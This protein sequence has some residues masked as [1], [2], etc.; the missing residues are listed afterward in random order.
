[1]IDEKKRAF[2]TAGLEFEEQAV[3]DGYRCIV[4][5]DEVGRGALAGP[6]VVGAVCL[7]INQPDL[8]ERLM[9][10]RDSKQ[11][12]PRQRAGLVEAIQ[13]LAVSWGI[14]SASADEIDQIGINPATFLAMGRALDELRNRKVD[15]EPDY[16]LLD[17]VK[18]TDAPCEQK[19]I[20]KG[21]QRSLSIAAASVLAKVWRDELMADLERQYPD[22]GLAAHKGYSTN[23]HREALQQRGVSAIHRKYYSRIRLLLEEA[24][25]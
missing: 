24:A 16:L 12:T 5:F 15:F 1:M 13:S 3:A 11:M 4:G 10:V 14:G 8:R 20:V 6:V 23:A 9:G 22:Y 2:R 19:N 7:P 18:W 17:S 21:D 25:E